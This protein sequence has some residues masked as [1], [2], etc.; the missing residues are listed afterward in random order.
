MHHAVHQV[1][2]HFREL[3]QHLASVLH[4]TQVDGMATTVIQGVGASV[5]Q[6]LQ[7]V[8]AT[9]KG[10][11]VDLFDVPGTGMAGEVVQFHG[12]ALARCTPQI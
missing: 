10:N 6:R 11:Q 1:E 5:D 7:Q 3:V 8:D 2:R 4:R 12:F 9:F